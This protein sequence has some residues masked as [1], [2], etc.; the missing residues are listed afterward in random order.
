MQKQRNAGVLPAVRSA[1]AWAQVDG[2][3]R[4]GWSPTAIASAAG[5]SGR[6]VIAAVRRRRLTGQDTTWSFGHAERLLALTPDAEPAEGFVN[7]VGARRRLRALACLGWSVA[8]ISATINGI[9]GAT[10]VGESTLFAIRGARTT[11]GIR[12]NFDQAIRSAYDE[13][14]MRQAPEGR[15]A[16]RARAHA[17]RGGW[18]PPLAYDDETIDD[19][20]PLV[21]RLAR[22]AVPDDSYPTSGDSACAPLRASKNSSQRQVPNSA[23]RTG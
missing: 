20:S 10:P 13:L 12:F 14:S 23:R 16:T 3:L 7:V 5:I 17:L 9:D 15:S 1:E 22:H 19:P 11:S 4:A 18:I 6:T 2:F 21:E 8:E